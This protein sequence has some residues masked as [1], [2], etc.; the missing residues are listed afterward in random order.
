MTS[1]GSIVVRGYR[2]ADLDDLIAIFTAAVRGTAGRDYTRAQARAWAPDAPDRT[3]WAA[4][5]ASRPTYVAEIG[6][7]AA[8]FSDLEPDGHI[9]MMFVHPHHQ[10]RGVAAAL[11]RHVEAQARMI[12]LPRLVTE[13]SRTARPFFARHGFTVVAE[14]QVPLRGEV[15]TNFRMEKRLA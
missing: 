10:G 13:A 9:D 14:Q 6:C 5:R 7:V 2:Q 8:G 12:N 11:L 3:A 1:Q 4:R 15:L